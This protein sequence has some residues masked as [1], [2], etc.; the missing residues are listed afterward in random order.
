M[1]QVYANYRKHMQNS[2][3]EK[4]GNSAAPSR[5][6]SIIFSQLGFVMV[7]VVGAIR[8]FSLDSSGKQQILASK[9]IC[10]ICDLLHLFQNNPELCLNCVRVTAKLS[11]QEPFRAQLNSKPSY[12][13]SI[14]RVILNEAEMC[15][16]VMDGEQGVVWPSWHTWPLLSRA[17]YTLGNMT[18][19]NDSNRFVGRVVVLVLVNGIVTNFLPCVGQ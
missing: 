14:A 7:Q 4:G 15:M 8:H 12:I 13:A 17:A 1:F 19:T 5:D 2:A 3:V 9:T 11:L 10:H 16:Q 6:E 18:T